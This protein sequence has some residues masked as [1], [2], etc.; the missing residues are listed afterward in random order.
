MRWV[1]GELK[2]AVATAAIESVQMM[3]LFLAAP[4]LSANEGLPPVFRGWCSQFDFAELVD[5]IGSV[6][7]I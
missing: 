4:H 6:I 3:D 7:E 2:V 1:D 5:E